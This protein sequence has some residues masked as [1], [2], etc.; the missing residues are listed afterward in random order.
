MMLF[1]RGGL[2]R[3]FDALDEELGRVG[4]RADLYVVGGAAMAIAYQARRA[5]IL[6]RSRSTKVNTSRSPPPYPA[7]CSP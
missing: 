4:V 3:A 7:S 2:L 1:D 5:T 6:N